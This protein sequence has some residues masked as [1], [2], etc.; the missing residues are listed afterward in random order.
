MKTDRVTPRYAY[1]KP[2]TVKFPGRCE[3]QNEFK[4]DIKGGLVW[5]T[6][7]RP[8][9][10]LVMRLIDEAQEGGTAGI[11]LHTTIFQVE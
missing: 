1:H 11:G 6:G 3:G 5:Y 10:A 7:L 9:K 8:I 4:P 2:F